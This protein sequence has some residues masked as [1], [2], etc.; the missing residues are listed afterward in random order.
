M[1]GSADLKVGRSAFQ[2]LE[3]LQER[4]RALQARLARAVQ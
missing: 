4:L 2:F 3:E 1:A